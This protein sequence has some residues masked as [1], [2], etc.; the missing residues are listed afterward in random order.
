MAKDV[1]GKYSEVHV[2]KA[3]GTPIP[4]DEPVFV[5]RAQDILAP[6]AVHHYARLFYGA[7][8]DYHHSSEIHAF[9]QVMTT[10]EPRKLPD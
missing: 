4:D 10:W 7:T 5:L 1:T 9:A 3:D 6:I 2:V 8:G